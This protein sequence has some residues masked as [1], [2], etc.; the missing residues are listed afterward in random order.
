[1]LVNLLKAGRD[2]DTSTKFIEQILVLLRGIS[3]S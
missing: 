3:V 1:M 2:E